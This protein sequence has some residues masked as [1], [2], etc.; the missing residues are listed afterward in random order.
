MF[1][2]FSVAE[3]FVD[4]SQKFVLLTKFVVI[5]AE[6]DSRQ[7]EFMKF[8]VLKYPANLSHFEELW[9]VNYNIF[10]LI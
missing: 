8:A 7:L 6:E 3:F 10:C 9:T 1:G 2:G 4:F 5:F